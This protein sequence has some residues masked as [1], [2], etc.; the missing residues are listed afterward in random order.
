MNVQQLLNNI[1]SFGIKPLTEGLSATRIQQFEKKDKR[2]LKAAQDA[3]NRMKALMKEFPELSNKTEE[4]L[5]QIL[6]QYIKNF[7]P[8]ESKTPYVPLAACGPWVV[9]VAGALVY[10]TGGYGM[11]GFGHNPQNILSALSTEQV[12]ANVMTPSFSQ[13]RCLNKLREAIGI[14]KECPYTHFIFMNSGSEAV[15][16]STRICDA[17]SKILT[18][19]GGKYE[20]RKIVTVSAVK[21]FH[22]RTG[23]AARISNSSLNTYRKHLASFRRIDDVLAVTL[24]RKDEL[25]AVFSRVSNGEIYIDALYLEPVQGEGCPGYSITAEYF[26]LARKLTKETSAFLVIDSIQAGLRCQGVLSVVDYPG[27]ENLEPPDMETFSKALNGGQFPLSVLALSKKA[28]ALYKRGIYGNTMTTNPRALDIIT[29]VL[30]ETTNEQFIKK[31]RQAGEI[32]LAKLG[33][34]KER[35]PEIILNV[36]GTG[37]LLSARIADHIPVVGR[38]SLEQMIRK[39]GVNIIHGGKNYLRFT[40]VFDISEDEINL[41]I[42]VIQ[43]VLEEVSKKG[44]SQDGS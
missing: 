13:Y 43:D 33:E 44:L 34:L 15:E 4:E 29:T 42:C 7:Y 14:G 40:P 6:P 35:Y 16:V 30:E 41:I 12:M 19:K 25:E 2:I 31:V 21:S 38:N 18:D 17:H 1:K 8:P 32:F 27:F 22:G 28:A 3:L 37:L 23:K 39:R 36:Q 20:G 10:D 9:T 24:N 11:L 26:E 5:V